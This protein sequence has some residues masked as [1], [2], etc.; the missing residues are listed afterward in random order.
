MRKEELLRARSIATASELYIDALYYHEMFHSA[1][2]WKQ[3]DVRS[4]L[5]NL[6][7][8]STKLDALK[9]NIKMRVIGL[10]WEDLRTPWS[11]TERIL[12]QLS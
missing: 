2:C 6:K 12:H 8:K 9:E 5:G 4:E 7:N 1:S 11:K 10:G 3:T